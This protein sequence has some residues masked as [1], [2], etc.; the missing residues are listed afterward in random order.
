MLK[1][2]G[3][4]IS[5]AARILSLSFYIYHRLTKDALFTEA[6]HAVSGR[7]MMNIITEIN[8]LFTR[9]SVRSSPCPEN[10]FVYIK[11]LTGEHPGAYSEAI[12]H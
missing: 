5:Q 4:K 2:D 10:A 9:A 6:V 7:L 1:K 3:Q 8:F 11:A 12:L